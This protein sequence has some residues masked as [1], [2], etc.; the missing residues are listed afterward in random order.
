MEQQEKLKST[1]N[2]GVGVD[3]PVRLEVG[4]VWRKSGPEHWLKVHSFQL[5]GEP[6][7]DGG[8]VGVSFDRLSRGGKRKTSMGI[9]LPVSS[10][11]K[12]IDWLKSTGR[13]PSA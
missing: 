13:Y 9:F 4:Q 1:D 2:P 10:K 11:E 5:P 7:Y 8:A 12:A 3:A 6:G